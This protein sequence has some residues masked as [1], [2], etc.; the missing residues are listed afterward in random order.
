MLAE[1]AESEATGEIAAIFAEVRE[2]WGVPYVSAIQRHLA[3]RPGFLEWA[4]EAV[5]PAFR[6]GAAQVAAEQA[7]AGVALAPLAAIP[8]D[9]LSVWGVDDSGLSAIRATAQGFV[10]VAP[11][12]MMFAGL[13]KALLVGAVPASAGRAKATMDWRKPNALPA[14]PPMIAVDKLDAAQRGVLLRFATATNGAPFVPGLYRILAHWPAFLAHLA[15]VLPPRL[16]ET[17]MTQAFDDIRARIDAAVPGVLATLQA[18]P[19][20]RA[21]PS[22]DERAHFVTIGATY[23]KTSPE[24]IVLGRLI[25]DALP[26]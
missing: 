3:T 7:A 25:G 14:P 1:V 16:M 17:A 2:L 10:R 18:R 8:R 23:R 9:A 11:I 13:V 6:S 12:N 4:W 5:G 21:M 20:S 26:S 22:H 15:T 19:V 24:L